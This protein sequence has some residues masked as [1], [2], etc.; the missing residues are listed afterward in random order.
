MEDK[1]KIES[2]KDYWSEFSG[3]GTSDTKT[4]EAFKFALDTR[5]FE[6]DLY[7]KRTAYF[8]TFISVVFTGF[9]LL[10]WEKTG[11]ESGI[12]DG[13]NG[14][15]QFFLACF[16]FVLSF[17]WYFTNRGSKQW[18]ENWEHHV[19]HLEERVTGPLYKTVMKRKLPQHQDLSDFK[20]KWHRYGSF[21]D[22]YIAGPSAHSV[23]K[24]NQIISLYVTLLWTV[25]LIYATFGNDKFQLNFYTTSVLMITFFTSVYI[26]VF[27]RTS[28]GPHGHYAT[29]RS[30]S[31]V[32]KK[33]E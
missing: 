25:L 18:Q 5:K 26:A 13:L 11:A 32:E 20:G 7:W 16:G 28:F 21:I 2:E 27:A 22:F 8:W 10:Q 12:P 15:I 1:R 3:N 24:I 9:G 30:S 19:D 23:S 4:I 14:T 29:V 17:S 31:I 33:D 6:I